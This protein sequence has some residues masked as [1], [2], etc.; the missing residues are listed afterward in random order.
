MLYES[1]GVSGSPSPLEARALHL[2]SVSPEDGA[3]VT[4]D[5]R[6]AYR[7]DTLTEWTEMAHSIEQRKLT[8]NFTT[9]KVKHALYSY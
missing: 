8:C 7:D 5:V 9:E 2:F 3:V 6:L 1:R 4:I